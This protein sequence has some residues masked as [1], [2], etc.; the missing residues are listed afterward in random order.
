MS[1]K[2]PPS[3]SSLGRC[4]SATSLFHYTDI[5]QSKHNTP[6]LR[7]NKYPNSPTFS[8]VHCHFPTIPL[9]GHAE[10]LQ[11]YHH[12][13]TIRGHTEHQHQAP[14]TDIP[15][16]QETLCFARAASKPAS[17]GKVAKPTDATE[18][19]HISNAKMASP[20]KSATRRSTR[21]I[22]SATTAAAKPIGIQ[23]PP[24][25][26]SAKK[27]SAKKQHTRRGKKGDTQT[28]SE[29]DEIILQTVTSE[30]AVPEVPQDTAKAPAEFVTE[31]VDQPFEGT[32]EPEDEVMV[33]VDD[34]DKDGTY[35][36]EP[37]PTKPARKKPGPKPGTKRGPHKESTARRT[38]SKITKHKDAV[39]K[40]KPI[41]G[42]QGK[43]ARSKTRKA[44]S[45]EP[46]EKDHDDKDSE[47]LPEADTSSSF[48]EPSDDK[49][50]SEEPQ[51]KQKR[52]Y[53]KKKKEPQEDGANKDG[54][55]K[56]GQP[57][58]LLVERGRAKFKALRAQLGINEGYTDDET[59]EETAKQKKKEKEAS[60]LW[61]VGKGH[62][63]RTNRG[64]KDSLIYAHE[65]QHIKHETFFV[66]E[67]PRFRCLEKDRDDPTIICGR[68]YTDP[69]G[70]KKHFGSDHF[71]WE[72]HCCATIFT[73]GDD[74]VVMRSACNAG[75]FLR[76]DKYCDHWRE[77]HSHIPSMHAINYAS[78]YYA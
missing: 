70:L 3:L 8:S 26:Q 32:S 18:S 9:D 46:E 49:P 72:T 33:D 12:G 58:K 59:D 25:N 39:D 31:Q 73:R 74:G 20:K 76:V 19:L 29:F 4:L 35:Q 36:P 78:P 37:E 21:N 13:A 61:G 42:K 7:E 2:G 10:D 43:K 24:K 75:P 65:F 54:E 66:D 51:K 62:G 6:Q 55:K 1:S 71:R 47:F 56:N 69:N 67:G 11:L 45:K 17:K 48:E 77:F 52:K 53:T 38:A 28:A 30:V 16:T 34:S 64:T 22:K 40:P 63:N 44:T 23:K 60:A 5:P 14:S 68:H 57:K 41:G 27:Q 15:H 50:A